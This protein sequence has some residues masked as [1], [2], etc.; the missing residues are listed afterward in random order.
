M[1]FGYGSAWTIVLAALAASTLQP[2]AHA[3]SR[4]GGA[5]VGGNPLDALPQIKAPDKGPSVTVQVAPQAPQL[6]ALLARHLT[7]TRVQV[8]GVKS[9]PFDEVARRFTPLV[10]KDTTIG[11]L[12]EVA[13]GVTKL[14]QARGFALSFAFIP[15]Q[16]FED[17]VVRVTVVEGY[18]SAVK[19]TG[20]AGAVEDRIRAIAAHITADRPLRRA[21]FERYINVLGLLPGVKV[22]ANVPP[23]QN[24][25]GATTLEL[26]VERKAFDVSTG[27]D[28]NH[29]G[30]QGLLS[31]TENG[32]TALGEQLSVSALLPKGRDNVTYLAAHATVPLG[33]NGLM[34]KIDASHYRGNP[35]NNPGLPSY[36]ERTVINDRI[37]GSLAYPIL[38]SNTQ[39]VIGTASVYASHDE[40]R[41]H[42]QQTGA[43]IGLRSQVRVMQLQADYTSV[44]T[45]QVR[46]ASLNVAKAFDILGASKSGDS[47]VPGAIV[48]N[49]ASINFV[50]TGASFSQTNEWPLKIG[51]AISLTGQY[52]A[53]SLPTS[54]Q[55]SFGAQRFAQGYRPGEASGDSGWGAMFEINRPFTPGFTYLRAFTP[56]VSIDAARVYLHAG[57]PSP[58][59]LSSIAFGFRISDA[60]YYSLDVSIA[61]AI[62]DA[63]VES[64]S[65]SPRI[66]AT[67]SYQLN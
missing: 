45:G 11:D 24:T 59:R 3:Q 66:N 28:F 12:I 25:D 38:L 32:L 5:A 64:A 27:I 54:E 56:Y 13:N 14:Y 20:K 36:V 65:R 42:N 4:P 23:P 8:E 48:G 40:D 18:V 21:T 60:K 34:S 9:I 67:F 30:V 46:R 39:S 16:T 29:P 50:R 26:N 15:A 1:K 19:I 49:P 22:A 51:T 35:V 47:N 2:Q 7:P 41:Y 63:P 44:E 31:A 10:G 58:S 43:Q 62:G 33:S 53:V 57:T 6:Q 55:I 37:V 17:G 52:S 61:K